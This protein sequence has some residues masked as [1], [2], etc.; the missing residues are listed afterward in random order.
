MTREKVIEV[1]HNA[2]GRLPRPQQFIRGT[3]LCEECMEH[4][5]TM[6]SL[7]PEQLPLEKLDNPGWDPICFACNEAYAYLMPALVELVLREADAYVQQFVF[8]LEQPERVAAFT[9]QQAAALNTV[10]DYLLLNETAAVENNLIFDELA[11]VQEKL[12]KIDTK[13]SSGATAEQ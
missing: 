1:V 13:T 11:S 7:P 5:A 12:S 3:C 2:F 8:H 4:E 9:A 6:Q 10:L